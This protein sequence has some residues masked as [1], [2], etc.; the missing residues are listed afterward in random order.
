LRGS[1]PNTKRL[2][3]TRLLITLKRK[4]HKSV[5]S[6]NIKTVPSPVENDFHSPG[7]HDR[8]TTL[9]KISPTLYIQTENLIQIIPKISPGIRH[10]LNSSYNHNHQ[11][12]NKNKAILTVHS[13]KS[14]N[15]I[16][17]TSVR[18]SGNTSVIS[19]G[20]NS[21]QSEMKIAQHTNLNN[22][23]QYNPK[24]IKT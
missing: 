22:R 2:V 19:K 4:Y 20:V 5:Y 14:K 13:T 17:N 6:K 18:L 3:S 7:N 8:D 21:D 1:Q 15:I 16:N 9:I 24:R 23:T 12:G 10:C 11:Y